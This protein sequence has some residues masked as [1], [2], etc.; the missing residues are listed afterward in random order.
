MNEPLE[1]ARGLADRLRAEGH[2]QAAQHVEH[3][4]L[5]ARIGTEVLDAIR[6]ACHFVLTTVEAIDPKT[7]LMAEEL[8]LELDK[9]L[10]R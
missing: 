6:G 9:L 5:G 1:R 2:D 3:A 8:R 7:Q 10:S 4:T